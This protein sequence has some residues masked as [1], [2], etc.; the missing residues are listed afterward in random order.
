MSCPALYSGLYI[1]TVFVDLIKN[2]SGNVF[3]L[4]MYSNYRG[5]SHLDK[6]LL[7][8]WIS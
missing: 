5:F 7:L 2:M 8:E 6:G 1:T 4:N 3:N